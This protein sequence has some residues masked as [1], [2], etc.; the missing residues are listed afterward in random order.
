MRGTIMIDAHVH[1]LHSPTGEYT[2]ELLQSFIDTA[3]E[4]NIEEIYLLEHTHQFLEFKEVYKPVSQYNSYQFE[5]LQR[6]L[7]VPIEKYLRFIEAAKKKDYPV[8]VSFGLEVCYI[9]DTEDKLAKV[10]GQYRFDFLTGSVHFVDNWAFD[11]KAE[12]WKGIDVDSTYRR[13]YMIMADLIRTGL[14][15]GLGHPDSIK[16]FGH[17]PTY[18]LTETYTGLSKL[19]NEKHMHTEHNGGL[20]LNFGH[21]ELGMNQA[22]LH[23][24]IKNGVKIMTASDAHKPEHTGANIRRLKELIDNCYK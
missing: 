9:P 13:Y 5:W 12:F 1:F 6:K 21:A 11:H 17:Y 15:D 7:S 24:F 14:F 22:M 20:A 19:L 23:I 4:R 10:L 2:F 16:C 3:V 18:D 8:K